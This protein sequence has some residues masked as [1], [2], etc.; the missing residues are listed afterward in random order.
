MICSV[1]F[2][3][4]FT[5]LRM[6]IFDGVDH[7]KRLTSASWPGPPAR[8]SGGGASILRKSLTCMEQRVGDFTELP[9]ITTMKM[10]TSGSSAPS[11][12]LLVQMA[13]N[14]PARSQDE[15]VSVMGLDHLC[16]VTLCKRKRHWICRRCGLCECYRPTRRRG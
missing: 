6:V 7:V 9:P 5:M 3:E 8:R 12:P 15:A 10:P 14:I 11:A 2:T 1:Y 4:P 16:H 13:Q